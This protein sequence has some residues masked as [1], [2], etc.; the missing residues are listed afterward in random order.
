M[1]IHKIIHH[2]LQ[3]HKRFCVF[4]T[5]EFSAHTVQSI[6]Y[7]SVVSFDWIVVVFQTKFFAGNR[8]SELQFSNSVKKFVESRFVIF[9]SITDKSYQFEIFV[10]IFS[11]EISCK[12]LAVTFFFYLRKKLNAVWKTAFVDE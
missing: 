2:M 9:K 4:K 6:F 11:C 12:N 1:R 7:F 8:N 3:I 5:F 10:E